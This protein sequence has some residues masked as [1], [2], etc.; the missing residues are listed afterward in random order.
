MI[1]DLDPNV[2]LLFIGTV[3]FAVILVFVDWLFKGEG[4]VFQ[5]IAGLLTGFSGALLA[6][7]K[8]KSNSG[9]GTPPAANA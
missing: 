6:M 2:R 8:A 5:V 3:F 7:I 9:G 1:K 4:Q